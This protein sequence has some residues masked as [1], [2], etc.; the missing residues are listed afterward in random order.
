M[1]KSK[2]SVSAQSLINQGIPASVIAQYGPN[3]NPQEAALIAQSVGANINFGAKIN[4]TE[5]SLL[6]QAVSSPA[7]AASTSTFAND[8]DY[9]SLS[10]DYKQMVDFSYQAMKADEADKIKKLQEALNEA[11]AQAEPYWKNVVTITLDELSRGIAESKGDFVSA[12]EN[13]TRRIQEI[14]QDL[15]LNRDSMT[16]EKQAE[17]SSLLADLTDKE[18]AYQRNVQYLGQEKA[19]ELAKLE[20]DYDNEVGSI[21]RDKE[22]LTAEEEQQL[23]NVQQEFARSRDAVI[24]AAADSGLTFD[25]KRAIAEQRVKEANTGMVESTKRQYGKQQAELAA[26]L[27]NQ[28]RQK[29]L[30]EAALG[31]SYGLKEA[32][33]T[34]SLNT[35]RRKTE[36]ERTGLERNYTTKLQQLELEASRGN[37]EATKQIEDLKRVYGED[38]TNLGRKAESYLGTANLPAIEGYSPLGSITGS[39]YEEKVADISKRQAAIYNTKVGASL[40]Y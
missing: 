1:A 36:E 27:A 13:L 19:G 40:N 6:A 34:A 35:Y 18:Q 17:L 14:Q 31:R 4:P 21:T 16:L 15:T 25:T 24:Q 12:N 26:N 20:A 30:N 10:N 11:T 7:P 3:I 22:Y 33:E 9:Q 39:M 23:K 5:A 2:G 38:I 8:P 37:L 29:A 28:N 32:E